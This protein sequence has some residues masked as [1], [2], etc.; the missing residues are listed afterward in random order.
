MIVSTAYQ[1]RMALPGV[2]E[3]VIAPLKIICW[4]ESYP[5]LLPQD[6]LDDL[7]LGREIRQW[8]PALE[9]GIAWIV[10]TA[11]LPVGFAHMR[12]AEITTLYV[13]RDHQGAGIGKRL[14]FHMFDEISCFGHTRAHLW[15]LEKNLLARE[16]YVHLGGALVARRPCGFRHHPGIMELCYE[17]DLEG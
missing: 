2:D 17:F 15:V 14:M 8:K 6:M 10:E 4:R 16:F 13:M 7:N 5:G 1:Y 3:T 9:Q 12:G 11:G